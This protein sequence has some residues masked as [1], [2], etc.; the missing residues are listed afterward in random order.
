MRWCRSGA[1]FFVCDG[2]KHRQ[3]L[4]YGGFFD[5]KQTGKDAPEMRC[6]INQRF[7]KPRARHIYNRRQFLHRSNAAARDLPDG[8]IVL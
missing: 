1:D 8:D 5:R 3:Y 6:R 2:E 7:L 4:T